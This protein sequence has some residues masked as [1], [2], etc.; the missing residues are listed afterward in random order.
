MRNK[1]KKMTTKLQRS[2]RAISPVLSVLMMIAIAVAASLVA[3]AWI[4][5]YLNFTTNKVGKAIQIQ[6][7]ALNDPSAGKV[8]VYVQNVGDSTVKLAN[9]Y[10][11]GNLNAATS[12]PAF[13]SDLAATTTAKIVL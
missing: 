12:D 13:G 1:A 6:S 11:D 7:V 9:I 4:M 8:S 2:I 5:G 3:Y 10:V